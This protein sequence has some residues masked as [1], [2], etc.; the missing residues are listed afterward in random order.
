MDKKNAKCE[1]GKIPASEAKYSATETGENFELA[2]VNRE[3]VAIRCRG[4]DIIYTVRSWI[5]S[6][7]WTAQHLQ[8]CYTRET[9]EWLCIVYL[10]STEHA[11][12]QTNIGT[13]YRKWQ[14][15]DAYFQ[16]E[17]CIR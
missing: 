11:S 13:Y 3:Q 2:F 5:I 14:D 4:V 9:T 8:T 17:R 1:L 16:R 6:K 10:G 7:L 12:H 15:V